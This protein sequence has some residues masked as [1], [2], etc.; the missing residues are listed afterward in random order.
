MLQSLVALYVVTVVI[1]SVGIVLYQA[2]STSVPTSFTQFQTSTSPSKVTSLRRLVRSHDEDDSYSSIFPAHVDDNDQSPGS[3]PED[4]PEEYLPGSIPPPTVFFW[5]DDSI[6]HSISLNQ[7]KFSDLSPQQ[8]KGAAVGNSLCFLALSVVLGTLG[9]RR[10]IGPRNLPY[11][12]GGDADS[13]NPESCHNVLPAS[14]IIDEPT[15]N[16]E[17][18]KPCISK[19]L[20]R[21]T[22]IR[23][24]GP[25]TKPLCPVP[26][27]PSLVPPVALSAAYGPS[28]RNNTR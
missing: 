5:R 6:T 27:R 28:T 14:I 17:L 13:V 8:P 20:A 2:P 1:P 7:K 3:H 16:Q 25:D 15:H 10:L 26:S 4:T 21:D 18:A 11:Q 23:P 19:T 22:W 24:R 12:D 9:I